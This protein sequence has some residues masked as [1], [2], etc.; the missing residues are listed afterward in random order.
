[1]LIGFEDQ[2]QFDDVGTEIGSHF[3][4]GIPVGVI[5]FT[6]GGSDRNES[7]AVRRGEPQDV[8]QRRLALNDVRFGGDEVGAEV[9][10]RQ[11][12]LREI[13]SSVESLD[14]H[15]R[16]DLTDGLRQLIHLLPACPD[17]GSSRYEIPVGFDD[18]PDI[19]LHRIFHLK[20]RA[21]G[22]DPG[23]DNR[24]EVGSDPAPLQ[25]RLG[26]LQEGGGIALRVERERTG[27]NLK[28]IRQHAEFCRTTEC[29]QFVQTGVGVEVVGAGSGDQRF[30]GVH[31]IEDGSGIFQA[32]PGIAGSEIRIE[33]G[34]LLV[35]GG[36]RD[37]RI[38]D[39]FATVGG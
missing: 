22:I 33:P 4:H 37:G 17:I 3:E 15:T 30:T 35:D 25:Q 10:E 20:E 16:F 9:G 2:L 36:V 8:P 27:L 34:V 13:T 18:P 39:G 19:L 5:R 23:N 28:G 1:M 7:R 11:L 32:V 31:R 12:G 26:V 21:F 29:V 14:S 38:V 6:N 24:S